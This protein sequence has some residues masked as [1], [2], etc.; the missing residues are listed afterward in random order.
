[1]KR[2]LASAIIAFYCLAA[3]YAGAA[4][5]WE[6]LGARQ[7]DFGRDRDTIEVGKSEGRFKQLQI[8]VKNAPIEISNVVVTFGNGQTF[9]PEVK[10]RFAEGTGTRVIDLPGDR[11]TIKKIDFNYRSVKKREGKGTLEVYAR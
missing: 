8:R 4:S 9:S 5:S 11:R 10:E 7:V 3:G 6:R 2:A 1:M